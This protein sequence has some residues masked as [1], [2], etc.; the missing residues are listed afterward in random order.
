[1]ISSKS[2]MPFLIGSLS[3]KQNYFFTQKIF[4]FRSVSKKI[5]L[6]VAQLPGTLEIVIICLVY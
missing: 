2:W 5:L 1:M 4:D 3:Y 6:Q